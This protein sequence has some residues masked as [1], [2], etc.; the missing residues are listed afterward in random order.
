MF[1][2]I[3]SYSI[4]VFALQITILKLLFLTGAQYRYDCWS[5]KNQ[6]RRLV[7]FSGGG[8]RRDGLKVA[9]LL[10]ATTISVIFNS[11]LFPLNLTLNLETF[12]VSINF[13]TIKIFKVQF[14]PNL[15]E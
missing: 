13:T 3:H 15:Y 11:F 9:Y 12:G 1:V 7:D 8:K 10:G 2:F 4:S 6:G 14:Q 5:N